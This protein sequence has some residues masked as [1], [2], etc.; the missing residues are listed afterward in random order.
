VA[1]SSSNTSASSST[2]LYGT[3]RGHASGILVLAPADGHQL[4]VK[5]HH[6]GLIDMRSRNNS[7]PKYDA[8]CTILQEYE[9]CGAQSDRSLSQLYPANIY[10]TYSILTP[11]SKLRSYSRARLLKECPA[12]IFLRQDSINTAWSACWMTCPS[13]VSFVAS[14]S[15]PVEMK[16]SVRSMDLIPINRKMSISPSIRC[17]VLGE[18]AARSCSCLCDAA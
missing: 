15:S 12:T 16:L 2:I 13:Q 18:A 4:L 7:F 17:T 1:W 14:F 6:A 3:L 11:S 5:T 8:L 10:C 9:F